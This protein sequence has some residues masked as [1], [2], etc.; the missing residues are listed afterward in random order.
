MRG[1]GDHMMF[2]GP[3]PRKR[4]RPAK[5]IWFSG[6]RLCKFPSCFP[7]VVL[8]AFS[9]GGAV[10]S[11]T[12]PPFRDFLSCNRRLLRIPYCL[13]GRVSGSR[14]CRP[15]GRPRFHFRAPGRRAGWPRNFLW[16]A[17]LAPAGW[18]PGPL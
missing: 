2:D 15:A 1:E 14:R 7:F 11:G 12:A 3:G 10:P 13:G 6:R 5:Q 17:G 4:P 18:P 16:V 8:E 9:C